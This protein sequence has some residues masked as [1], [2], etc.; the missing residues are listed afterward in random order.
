MGISL[1]SQSITG[2]RT[3]QAALVKNCTLGR[4]FRDTG[5]DK[6]DFTGS[7][8]RQPRSPETAL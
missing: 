7:V 2:A 4:N 8:K 6:S 1:R 5:F 3:R